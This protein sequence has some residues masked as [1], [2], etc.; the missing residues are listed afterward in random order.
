[1]MER[2]RRRF[3]GF[4]LIELLVVIAIIAILA[5]IL[6]PALHKAR[7]KA[8]QGV[9]MN[10]LKQIGI[11]FTMYAQDNDG[12]TPPWS[13]THCH[14]SHWVNSHRIR[15]NL[16]LLSEYLGGTSA[17]CFGD[18]RPKV[19]RCPSGPK[20]HGFRRYPTHCDYGYNPDFF[21]GEKLCKQRPG[22][23]S[24]VDCLGSFDRTSHNGGVNA[25]YADGH[26]IWVSG[27]VYLGKAWHWEVFND[28]R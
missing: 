17:D 9:C 6:L 22:I 14:C 20:D 25:L 8:R 10:N 12:Y 13:P 15:I 26:V 3:G 24:V 28:L 23:M 27:Q 16:G 4:T 7:E 18:T 19:L 2:I 21:S 5:A 11:A 1:M